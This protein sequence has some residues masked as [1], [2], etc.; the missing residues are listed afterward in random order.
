MYRNILIASDGS[1]LS[2]RAIEQGV[3][4]I[5]LIDGRIPHALVGELFTKD[6]VGSLVSRQVSDAQQTQASV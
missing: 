3:A 2:A 1:E 4:A 5:H 6:G